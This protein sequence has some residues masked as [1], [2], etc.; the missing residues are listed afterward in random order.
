M[1]TGPRWCHDD[2]ISGSEVG[3]RIADDDDVVID[4][5]GCD[6]ATADHVM[7]H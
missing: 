6:T 1:I 5:V 7:S 2:V 3:M 4:V